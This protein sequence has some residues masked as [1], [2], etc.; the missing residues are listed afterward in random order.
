MG[1]AKGLGLKG[2]YCFWACESSLA[3]R[4]VADGVGERRRAKFALAGLLLGFTSSFRERG[5]QARVRRFTFRHACFFCLVTQFPSAPRSPFMLRGRHRHYATGEASSLC[6]GGGIVTSGAF[7][8]FWARWSTPAENR[9]FLHC[10]KLAVKLVGRERVKPNPAATVTPAV[11]TSGPEPCAKS[12]I[13]ADKSW[14]CQPRSECKRTRHSDFIRSN[15]TPIE[16]PQGLT[17]IPACSILST[18]GDVVGEEPGILWGEAE[19][20][21]PSGDRV[22]RF[23]RRY[24]Q[25]PFRAWCRPWLG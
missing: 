18:S 8:S 25:C 19:P 11:G 15:S 6:Y 5:P 4:G 7:R 24:S 14:I 23:G 1:R 16:T 12:I 21:Q 22:L 2:R 3:A 13:P 20:N 10:P 9:R 17:F